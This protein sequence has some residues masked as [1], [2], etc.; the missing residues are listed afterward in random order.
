MSTEA[1]PPIASSLANAQPVATKRTREDQVA[2][3]AAD[4]ARQEAD[5]RALRN[6]KVVEAAQKRYA[7]CL[8]KTVFA[9]FA[10]THI[11]DIKKPDVGA[12]LLAYLNMRTQTNKWPQA[13]ITPNFVC[14]S[15]LFAPGSRYEGAGANNQFEMG[16]TIQSGRSSS[17]I[18]KAYPGGTYGLEQKQF[19]LDLARNIEDHISRPMFENF[20]SGGLVASKFTKE[21]LDG[22]KAALAKERGVVKSD[23]LNTDP[24]LKADAWAQWLETFKIPITPVGW[25]TPETP[26]NADP[27]H[28]STFMKDAKTGKWKEAKDLPDMQMMVK[29]H[30]FVAPADKAKAKIK[31]TAPVITKEEAKDARLVVERYKAAGFIVKQPTVSDWQGKQIMPPLDPTVPV[32]TNH[33]TV[34]VAFTIDPTTPSNNV[35]YTGVHFG[36]AHMGVCLIELGADMER[37]TF[38]TGVASEVDA[39]TFNRPLEAQNAAKEAALA[40]LAA[41]EEAP[42]AKRQHTDEVAPTNADPSQPNAGPFAAI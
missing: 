24:D 18:E 23:I 27:P 30:T 3:Y 36:L 19:F 42:V 22:A 38:G 29:Q 6:K 20:F 8:Y 9:N 25:R 12:N 21:L 10:A 2:A 16:V 1:T 39:D 11:M 26:E 13:I 37:A 17:S 40:V 28:Y 31:L 7:E 5:E 33:S 41:S 14:F 34:A 35:N 4:L 32:V 15:S